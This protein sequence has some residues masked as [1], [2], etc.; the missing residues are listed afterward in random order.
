VFIIK[1]FK[2]IRN[3]YNIINII[4]CDKVVWLLTDGWFKRFL[5]TSVVFVQIVLILDLTT[6]MRIIYANAAAEG[7]E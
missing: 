6:R 3:K 4:T 5:Q 7:G 2:T 1:D